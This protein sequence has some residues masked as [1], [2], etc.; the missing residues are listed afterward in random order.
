MRAFPATT[1]LP[2]LMTVMKAL[3]TYCDA[4]RRQHAGQRRDHAARLVP[5]RGPDRECYGVDVT[6]IDPERARHLRVLHGC[7]AR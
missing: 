3:A 2:P 4:H 5:K 7:R 6:R 1:A